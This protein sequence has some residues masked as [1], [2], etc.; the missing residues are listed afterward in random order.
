MQISAH[1]HV[2]VSH[3]TEQLRLSLGTL[4]EHLV[5]SQLEAVMALECSTELAGELRVG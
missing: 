2:Q 1:V 3:C 4:L 5:R